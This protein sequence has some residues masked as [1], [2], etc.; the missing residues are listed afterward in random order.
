VLPQ[1]RQLEFDRFHQG[2]RLEVVLA[3]ASAGALEKRVAGDGALQ[4]PLDFGDLLAG[5]GAGAPVLELRKRTSCQPASV[6]RPCPCMLSEE[7]ARRAGVRHRIL[8]QLLAQA[9][10]AFSGPFACAFGAVLSGLVLCSQGRLRRE[11][12]VGSR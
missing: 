7:L 1:T 6:R 4:P 12:H 10:G 8:Q 5:G 11:Q 9:A 3:R 2:V